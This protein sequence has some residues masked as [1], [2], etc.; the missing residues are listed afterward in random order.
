M[1]PDQLVW[2]LTNSGDGQ[3]GCF[4]FMPKAA[5]HR[6]RVLAPPETAAVEWAAAREPSL[7]YLIRYAHRAFVK[8][9]AH[10]LAPHGISPG[11]WSVLRV[12]WSEEGLTQ[13]ELAER[14][15]VEKASLTSVLNGL[16]SKALVQRVRNRD[17]RRKFNLGVTPAGRRLKTQLLACGQAIN[18]KATRGM[19]GP[20]VAQART[21]LRTF[22]ANLEPPGAR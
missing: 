4:S 20:A 12:L 5:R 19:P 18:D 9:L 8:A 7:G 11:E 3:Q 1:A 6:P 13:V 15:R 2:Y 17:D 21:L 16:E 14:M 10:E 22:I